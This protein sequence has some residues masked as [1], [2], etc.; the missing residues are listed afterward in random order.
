M[1]KHMKVRDVQRVPELWVSP[2]LGCSH[3]GA[4]SAEWVSKPFLFLLAPGSEELSKFA[5]LGG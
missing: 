4:I 1:F 2:A 3:W 5:I